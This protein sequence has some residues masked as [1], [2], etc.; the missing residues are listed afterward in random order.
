MILIMDNNVRREI[1]TKAKK[2]IDENVDGFHELGSGHRETIEDDHIKMVSAEMGYTL[3][4]FY[5]V[6]GDELI[7]IL[8]IFNQ[9]ID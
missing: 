9:T 2:L 8:S 4:E 1:V 6:D 3:V 5:D 7:P